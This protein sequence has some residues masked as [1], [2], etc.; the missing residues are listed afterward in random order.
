MGL[1][2]G[3]FS[4]KWLVIAATSV[5]AMLLALSEVSASLGE[6]YQHTIR[7]VIGMEVCL[8][9]AYVAW[10]GIDGV[11]LGFAAMFGFLVAHKTQNVLVL[12]QADTDSVKY[13]WMV[14]G[15]YSVLV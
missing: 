3:E 4:F 10:K 7:H 8:G 13:H 1:L 12:M 6:D 5:V 2:D 14:A 15:W 11:L 9:T